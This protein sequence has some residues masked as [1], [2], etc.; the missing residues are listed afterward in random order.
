[1]LGNG[2]NIAVVDIGSNTVRL[3]VSQVK[4]KSY[5]VL[6]EYKESVRLGD[7]VFE[8]GMITEPAL[9][10]LLVS[11]KEVRA[12]I[13]NWKVHQVRAVATASFRGAS[14]YSEVIQKVTDVCGFG[15]EMI[16]GEE[17]ARYTFIAASANFQISKYH[18]LVLDIGGGSAEYSVVN[19]GR[20]EKAHSVELGC[21]RLTKQFIKSD[22]VTNTE[23]QTLKDFLVKEVRKL[24]LP[25]T[26]DLLICT[27][28]SM[29][30]LSTI[31]YLACGQRAD[32]TVKYLERKHL[33]KLINDIRNKT[34]A[35]RI[36]IPGMEEKRADIILAA[37]MQ[38]D[39]VLEETDGEGL[40]TLSGGLRSGL[41]I[42]TIN[43]MGLELPF[44]SN[45]DNVRHSRLI[46]IGNKFSFEERHARQVTKL[47]R[48]LFDGLHA[49]LGLDKADWAVL[50]AASLLHDI[51]NYISYSSHHKQSQYLIMNSDLMGYSHD[52]IIMI[53]NIARYHRKSPPRQSHR[54]FRMMTGD[55]QRK[56]AAMSAVLR[57]ADGLDRSHKSLVRDLEVLVK[58]KKI[59]IKLISDHNLSLEKKKFEMKKDLLEEISGTEL[60]IL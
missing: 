8:Y 60:I 18:A 26:I 35:E 51:G 38:V 1:M 37:A 52:E 30:N 25:R 33:K 7:E 6:E 53:G 57:A 27:G 28:G 43:K 11:L 47:A 45:M 23:Y 41:T 54:Y 48:K 44:Q 50:E 46:E 24:K 29:G 10:R 2:I 14:N 49:E 21:N 17:E 58:P 22:P 42:D 5:R 36:Q 39:A 34:I 16:S 32:R 13:D 3:Q 40:Y 15:V 31:H 20:L 19:K 56:I 9:N 4:D 55:G 59:E 12:I